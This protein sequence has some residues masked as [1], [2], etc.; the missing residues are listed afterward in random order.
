MK[1]IKGRE[2]KMAADPS[3][4]QQHAINKFIQKKEQKLRTMA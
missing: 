2:K 4:T 1:T 3:F